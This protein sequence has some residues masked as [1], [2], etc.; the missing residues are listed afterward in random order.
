MQAHRE[1][2]LLLGLGALCVAGKKEDK[3]IVLQRDMSTQG[4]TVGTP[5][6]TQ[7]ILRLPQDTRNQKK[8]GK[9]FK[10]KKERTFVEEGAHRVGS[11]LHH[12]TPALS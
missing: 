7:R 6:S 8:K 9:K 2:E 10:K 1:D 5:P 12:L 3:S 11:L 4:S